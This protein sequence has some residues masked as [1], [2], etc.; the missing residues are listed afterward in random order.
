MEGSSS[1][2]RG[3]NCM[4]D[5]LEVRTVPLSIVWYAHEKEW[6]VGRKDR[7]CF[8]PVSMRRHVTDTGNV[9]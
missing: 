2:E 5:R 8:R 4:K 1:G 6:L 7:S 9:L 3:M